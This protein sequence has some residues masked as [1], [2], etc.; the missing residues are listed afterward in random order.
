MRLI[1]YRVPRNNYS[2]G[3]G[4]RHHGGH[5][6][7]LEYAGSIHF[8][9]PFTFQLWW[10]NITG[11]SKLIS[12]LSAISENIAWAVLL[13]VHPLDHSAFHKSPLASNLDRRYLPALRPQPH[14][15]SANAKSSRYRRRRE[16]SR[17][18]IG[19]HEGSFGQVCVGGG[20][21]FISEPLGQAGI[22]ITLRII[23]AP[24]YF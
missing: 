12:L 3:D 7:S 21:V 19:R 10:K 4:E 15:P 22:R 14:R 5:H 8:H 24:Y 23:A 1:V 2:T 11:L 13:S 6:K 16:E 17:L 18:G 9:P 20:M